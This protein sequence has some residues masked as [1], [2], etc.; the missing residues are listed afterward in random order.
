[1]I[2]GSN[3]IMPLTSGGYD[4]S[5]KIS[6]GGGITVTNALLIT[7][8]QINIGEGSSSNT[9]SI[10][11]GATWNLSA[12]GI[13]LGAGQG[14][15][16]TGN[17]L[18]VNGGTVT[19]VSGG[20]LIGGNGGIGN[21]VIITNGAILL[22]AA[23]AGTIGGS[24]NTS[25][26]SSNSLLILAGGILNMDQGDI[27]LGMS[28]GVSSSN[29]V[30]VNAGMITNFT[31][32]EI[33]NSGGFNTLLIT[34]GGK[35]FG[36]A[37]SAKNSTIG[38]ASTNNTAIITGSGSQWQ[39]INNNDYLYIGVNGGLS[40]VVSVNAGGLLSVAA[41]IYIGSSK[42]AQNSLVITDGATNIVVGS[43]Y[44]GSG[45][46]SVS[47]AYII[48]GGSASASSTVVSNGLITVGS[49]GGGYNT[50]TVTNASV[51]SAGLVVG[52]GS[53][54][55][56][57]AINSNV[58]WNMLNTTGTIGTLSSY[59][60]NSL[61][62]DS[63]AQ[64]TG[65]VAVTYSVVNSSS[66]TVLVSGSSAVWSNIN[67]LTIGN[68]GVANQL[69][70]TNGGKV[71]SGTGMIGTWST[72]NTNSIDTSVATGIVTVVAV[73]NVAN[74]AN[75]SLVTVAGSGSSLIITGSVTLGNSSS[76]N[77][78]ALA[79]GASFFSSNITIGSFATLQA[80]I[81]NAYNVGGSG[82]QVTAS[83]GTI[84]V[85]ST[86]S[87]FNAMNVTNA[88]LQSGTATIGNGSSNNTVSVSSNATWKL[89][90]SALNIGTGAATGNVLQI[91]TS[92]LVSNLATLNI[93]TGNSLILNG[94]VL[95]AGTVTNT[96]MITG[97]GQL[98]VTGAISNQATLSAVGGNLIVAGVLTGTG[99]NFA[100]NA[101]T[102]TLQGVNTYTGLT[103]LDG[104]TVVITNDSNLGATSASVIFN[105]GGVLQVLSN[106]TLNA[107]RGITLNNA[108]GTIDSSNQTTAV[109]GIISGA[110]ALTKIGSGTLTLASNNTY[111]GFTIIS[112][113]T[114]QVGA[115]GTSGVLG[116][117]T[118]S[119]YA[120]LVFNRSDLFTNSNLIAGTGNL[121][122]NGTGSTAILV[123]NNTYS[124]FTIISNGTLQVGAGGTSGVLG[125]GTV[126]NYAVLTF[127]RSDTFTNSNLIA[128]TGWLVKAGTGTLVLSNANSYSGGTVVNTGTLVVQANGAVG[129]GMITNNATVELGSA[130]AMNMVND[131]LLNTGT[132][133]V[134]SSASNSTWNGNVNLVNATIMNT[135]GALTVNGTITG[136]G[137]LTKL[138]SGALTLTN[139]N[140]FTGDTIISAGTVIVSNQ[141]ALQNSTV[142]YSAGGVGFGSGIT[143]VNFGGLSGSSNLALTNAD[144]AA[145][146]L[147]VGANSA[148]TT[149]S[150]V[151][152]ELGALVKTGTGTLTISGNNNYNGG[153]T[154]SNGW[155]AVGNNNAVG[156]GSLTMAGGTL[157]TTGS[158]ILTNSVILAS[159]GTFDTA[160]NSLTLSG[161]IAGAS[162]LVK[163]GGGTL[164]FLGTNTYSGITVINQGVVVLA[165]AGGL[166]NS[167]VTPN[168][169]GGLL[170]SNATSFIVGGLAGTGNVSLATVA[171]AAI[172]L[173][174][175][176]NK[177][178]TTYGGILSGAGSLTIV[179]GTL[180]LTNAN[181]Y[182]GGTV[183]NGGTLQANNSTGSGL[184]TGTVIVNSGG[185][186]G[187]TGT[188]SG[189]V[190]VNSGG[191]LAPGNNPVVG[192]QQLGTLTL[193]AGSMLDFQFQT[194]AP[195][196][197]DQ[198]RVN[199]ANGLTINGAGINLLTGTNPSDPSQ[200][201]TTIGSYDLIQYN[202]TLQ[203]VGIAGLTVLNGA[204][205]RTYAFGESNN[206]V[207]VTIGGQGVGWT[208]TA[209]LPSGPWNWSNAGNWVS[210]VSTGSFLIFDGNTGVNNNNDFA[211][212]TWFS[213][214]SFTNTAGA[215]TLNGNALNLRGNIVNLSSA[216][217]TLNLP[218]TL[219]GGSRI[220][221]TA[222]GNLVMSGVVSEAT[223]GL[224]I[225][226]TS[227]QT[228]V[229]NGS[230]TF[231]GVTEIQGGALR[232][233]DGVGL[234]TGSNLKLNGGV[235]ESAG[236]FTRSLGTIAGAVQWGGSGGFAAQG[237]T[238]TVNINN[239]AGTL[240][241]GGTANFIGSGNVL[242]FGASDAGNTVQF[243][244]PLNLNGAVQ[245]I[246]VDGVA[247]IGAD[248]LGGI[249]GTGSSGIIKTGTGTMRLSSASSFSGALTV[250]AGTLL[251][252]CTLS[253]SGGMFVNSGATIGGTGIFN[254]TLTL[255]SGGT[256]APGMGGAGVLTVSSLNLTNGFVYNWELGLTAT[257]RV[258]VTTASGL[259]YLGT[260]WT[261]NLS[262]EAG[263]SDL[264]QWQ[265]SGVLTDSFVLFQLASGSAPAG[266]TNDVTFVGNDNWDVSQA[267]V[268]VVGNQVLLTGV[269]FNSALAVIPEP[270]VLLMWLAGGVT[271]W[272]A[273]R[274]HRAKNL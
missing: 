248:F 240:I 177:S 89:L 182:G 79:D 192:A 227:N 7:G 214:I 117:G 259:A 136:S 201:F 151:L 51:W 202:G 28:T 175:G 234:P 169:N 125:S 154:L 17:I 164:T 139:A 62:I 251:L 183:I 221:D 35:V 222:G 205:N 171:N 41:S 65:T 108:G 110:G 246:N 195:F 269:Y 90:G 72:Y 31:K 170:F 99:T 210:T 98:Q 228:L 141:N 127:N 102:L 63:T 84:I 12:K 156:N 83:N 216:T 4:G 16:A 24:G 71:F 2:G 217:Q 3:S 9:V 44:V 26:S 135:P 34:N 208:G 257:D 37:Q 226:K 199:N 232:A 36:G 70:I 112:N 262:A 150:G 119:N 235:L 239:N 204:N 161:T 53:S 219:D 271:L 42:G 184:G 69:A 244:N 238:L 231:T 189:A 33:G 241:W 134:D 207:T 140:I 92:G 87:G 153:T 211:A 61:F 137:S 68:S 263:V 186:L 245:T 100:E 58:K 266:L 103:W 181:T 213:G 180:N 30:T 224:G 29:L 152:S 52:N 237:G 82:A 6:N 218:V 209:G 149:Y 155:L 67:V 200:T 109:Q 95:A 131:L 203:G 253:S 81:S 97:Y 18:T 115:G 144:A 265:G 104:G 77:I 190:T 114:L 258:D 93:A 264:S 64:K 250:D 256:L 138:G 187:G 19:N 94:G 15:S 85:G 179:G 194:N 270:S 66:N 74:F 39:I 1:M 229:L 212:H 122:Q 252:A 11:G 198:I 247:A 249:S 225:V 50:M 172:G 274:R 96:G 142:N 132:L 197:Y 78:L 143:R 242:K 174:V 157:T 267:R 27:E 128:G 159:V 21:Q 5:T 48:N 167:T 133:V 163:T 56:T 47:N 46:G 158:R 223:A 173:S 124:G 113:G 116:S 233:T 230:N 59:T 54:N 105:S 14:S 272:A 23:N 25:A 75:N 196:A 191:Y 168:V 91:N 220:F 178:S 43:V 86:S 162:A 73:T 185:T 38:S 236:T 60:T 80:G 130:S 45:A 10:L 57:V 8:D 206:W 118:V 243:V 215:F 255:G 260:N 145:V 160:G 193:N 88:Q 166:T 76:S 148:N 40:N 129:N 176:N 22:A 273:R 254:N 188:I 165:Q 268:S 55:N 49:A 107:S 101:G 123:S 126:S 13:G 261:L 111:S 106:T 32:M 147:A 120:T 20:I 121:I 146:T